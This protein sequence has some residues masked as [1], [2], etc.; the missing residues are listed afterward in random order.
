MYPLWYLILSHV[1]IEQQPCAEQAALFNTSMTAFGFT[2]AGEWSLG[3]NDCGE[4]L[5]GVNRGTRYEGTYDNTTTVVQGSCDDFTDSSAF[6]STYKSQLVD[7]AYVQMDTF[8]V[9][10]S[11]GDDA[12]IS[13]ESTL[14]TDISSPLALSST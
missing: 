7:F 8:Q 9:R 13:I 6:N 11:R 12:C 2:Y 14:E 4:F 3:T 5:N 10:Q 1:V